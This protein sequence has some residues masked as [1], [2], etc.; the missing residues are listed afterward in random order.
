A[1]R[2]PAAIR[3]SSRRPRHGRPRPRWIAWRRR[4]PPRSASPMADP[5]AM[6]QLWYGRDLVSSL[7]RAMLTPA[8]LVYSG[9]TGARDAMYDVGW[10][11]TYRARI[12]VVSVGNLTVGGTGKT[13]IAAWIARGLVARGARP[14]IVLR[15]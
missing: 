7:T 2:L 8:S 6:E 4:W 12:S 9:I 15:G 5:R 14:A 10:L 13:P 1:S 3:C 11:R